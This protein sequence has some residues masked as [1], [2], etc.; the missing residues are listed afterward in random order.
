MCKFAVV[1]VAWFN[2]E[3]LHESLGDIPPVEYEQLHATRSPIAGDGSVAATISPRA[4]DGLRT[5]RLER[6]D[7]ET[8]VD[9]PFEPGHATRARTVL[10][11]AATEV[12]Q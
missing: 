2:N 7:S 11:Q 4:A 9:G 8:A 6:A 12:V 10:A 5:R 1:W 3:R